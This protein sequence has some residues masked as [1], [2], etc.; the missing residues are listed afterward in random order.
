MPIDFPSS[1]TTGQVYTYL[2]KSWVY[3]GTGWDAPRALSE[4]GAVQTFANATARTAA[5]PSPTEG[6]VTYLND[7]DALQ[8][9][10]G[11]A[12][13]SNYGLT[14]VKS[15]SFTSATIL[16]LDGVF[17]SEFDNYKIIFTGQKSSTGYLYWR[18]RAAGADVTA[19]YSFN[20]FRVSGTTTNTN[21]TNGLGYLPSA[22]AAG[23][24]AYFSWLFEVYNPARTVFTPFT[25]RWYSDNGSVYWSGDY[26]GNQ[27]QALA[28][29]GFAIS[30][31]AG[32]SFT[33]QVKVFGYR[34]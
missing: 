27:N 5:I 34:S 8:V 10:S 23:G 29:D 12:W 24:G 28:R 15:Q 25:A 7:V 2:G 31:D 16:N 32:G 17:T 11:S 14:L 20:G 4:I 18:L 9:Y 6:I 21:S 1:P 26:I 19:S 3:N 13:V 33:G 30:Q 22:D